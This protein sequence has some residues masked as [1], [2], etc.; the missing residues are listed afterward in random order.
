M[1]FIYIFKF[2]IIMIKLNY[3]KLYIYS[4]PQEC[5]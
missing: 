3:F 1:Y 4:I 2:Y 5:N